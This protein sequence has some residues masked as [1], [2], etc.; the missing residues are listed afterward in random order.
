MEKF[1]DVRP[2]VDKSGSVRV[3]FGFRDLLLVFALYFETNVRDSL[4]H[5]E[6]EL[7]QFNQL[8]N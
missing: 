2:F 5:Y 4:S 7:N 3:S 1:P 8:I 6:R